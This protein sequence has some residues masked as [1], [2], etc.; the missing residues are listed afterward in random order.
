M[1]RGFLQLRVGQIASSAGNWFSDPGEMLEALEC[2][3]KNRARGGGVDCPSPRLRESA[4]AHSALRQGAGAASEPPPA[5]D[6]RTRLDRRES[7]RPPA[8]GTPLPRKVSVR[9]A[10]SEGNP[11]LLWPQP[12]CS[13]RTCVGTVSS[14]AFGTGTGAVTCVLA[15]W[16]VA[17]HAFSP[18]GA[19]ASK[20]T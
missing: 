18:C 17:R 16:S 8:E 6:D 14:G 11:Q 7:K 1:L 13:T 9:L 15:P 2:S 19:F 12:T 10:S 5:G 3:N 4:A 20:L